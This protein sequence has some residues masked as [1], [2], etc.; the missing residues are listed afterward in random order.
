MLHV[1]L[2]VSEICEMP[3]AVKE[4]FYR[5]AQEA[6][7]N[8]VKHANAERVT[9]GLIGSLGD[10]S[11][12]DEQIEMWVVDNGEGFDPGRIPPDHLGVGIMRERA[13]GIGA[14]LEL[15]SRPGFGT[16]IQV[17]WSENHERRDKDVVAGT[18][19]S[20]AG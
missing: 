15:A 2:Q 5:I 18:D 20:Y 9:V 8:V 12:Q 4:A 1:D 10:T 7:N 16:K 3:V 11:G 6:L 17:L 13:E 19:S 14:H